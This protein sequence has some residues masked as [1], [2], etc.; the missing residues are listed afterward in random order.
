MIVFSLPS[1]LR[2]V[3]GAAIVVVLIGALIVIH[4]LSSSSNGFARHSQAAQLP[5]QNVLSS[6]LAKNFGVVPKLIHQSWTST[7][8]PA[9]FEVWSRTCREQNPDWQWVLWTDEDNLNLVK[10]YFPWFLEYYEKLPGE[11][12]RADLVRNMYMYLYGGMYADLD[13]E[14]LRPANELF[15]SHNVTTV[16][17]S[18][19]YDGSYHSSSKAQDERKAFFGRMGTDDNFDHSIPNAWMASTPG[20]P[21]FLLSLEGVIEKLKEG[22]PAKIKAEALTGPIALRERINLYRDKYR[23][24]DELDQRL[25]NSPMAGVFGPQD[26][27]KHAVEVLPFWNVYPFSWNLDGNAFK[28]ICSVNS[29]G[30]DRERCKLVVAVDH[31]GSY[32]ITYWSH[33]WSAK[34]HNSNNLKN[35]QGGG[36]R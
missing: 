30:Y 32:F 17:Y 36:A 11:I 3:V 31:W 5:A 12:Y 4:N 19:S 9:K 2:R 28:G 25:S 16:P 26:R 8:L 34:G 6:P 22:D 15:K 13:L 1:P 33:T 29:P 35:I 23:D 7:D 14:C 24:S 18:S 27:M 20:H 10:K 21:F